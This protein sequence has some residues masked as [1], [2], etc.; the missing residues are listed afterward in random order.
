MAAPVMHQSETEREAQV[1]TMLN[2]PDVPDDAKAMEME[3]G[4]LAVSPEFSRKLDDIVTKQLAWA[5][6]VEHWYEDY[7]D[8]LRHGMRAC[9][10]IA[11]GRLETHLIHR[12]NPWFPLR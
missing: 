4:R 7:Q 9:A 6:Q 12:S 5:R 3:P 2:R 1:P 11:R 8:C 10:T